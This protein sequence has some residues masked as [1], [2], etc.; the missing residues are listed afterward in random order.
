[1]TGVGDGS[2][3]CLKTVCDFLRAAPDRDTQ[4]VQVERISSRR[5]MTKEVRATLCESHALN[6]RSVASRHARPRDEEVSRV[7][8]RAPRLENLHPVS[9]V[10]PAFPWAPASPRV[11]ARICGTPDDERQRQIAPLCGP[12]QGGGQALPSALRRHRQT[13]QAAGKGLGS[14]AALGPQSLPAQYRR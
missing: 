3:S 14:A 5:L 1:M 11:L 4:Q 8:L 7:E 2:P 10:A 6:R 13:F 12:D 9:R